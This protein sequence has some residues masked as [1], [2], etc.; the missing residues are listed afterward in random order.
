LPILAKEKIDSLTLIQPF[1]HAGQLIQRHLALTQ[2]QIEALHAIYDLYDPN[3]NI[4]NENS[5]VLMELWDKRANLKAL[6]SWWNNLN[7]GIQI[8]SVGRVLAHSNAQRCDKNLPP[9][10]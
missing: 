9:L 1:P 6:K 2:S 7:V 4:K 10:N 8:T 3:V 5:R